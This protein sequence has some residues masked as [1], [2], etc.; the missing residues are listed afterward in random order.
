MNGG[1]IYLRALG[2]PTCLS[3]KTLTFDVYC[4]SRTAKGFFLEFSKI[5]EFR[6]PKIQV[7]QLHLKVDPLNR[8]V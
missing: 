8:V 6:F 5:L 3:C 7:N 1:A 2:L 4:G